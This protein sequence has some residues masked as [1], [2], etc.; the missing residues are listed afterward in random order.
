[1]FRAGANP[2]R[3][4]FPAARKPRAYLRV[5][6]FDTCVSPLGR[7]DKL[8]TLCNPASLQAWVHRP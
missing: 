1:M 3:C 6:P 4:A 8:A 7:A 2:L 5:R